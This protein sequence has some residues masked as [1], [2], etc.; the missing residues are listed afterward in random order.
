MGKGVMGGTSEFYG[1]TTYR[2]YHSRPDLIA[3]AMT[4]NTR[5]TAW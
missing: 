5:A 2:H 3:T 1:D 4:W